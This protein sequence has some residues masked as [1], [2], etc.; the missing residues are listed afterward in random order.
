MNSFGRLFRV[1][2]Y[3]ESHQQAIGVVIDG[4]KPGTKFDEALLLN[5]LE[6]RKSRRNWNDQKGGTRRTDYHIWYL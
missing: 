1:T 5:D 2:I 6:R 4:V 3:G